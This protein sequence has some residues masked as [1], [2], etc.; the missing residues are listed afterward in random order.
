MISKNIAKQG[1]ATYNPTYV[2]M[3]Y[4]LPSTQAYLTKSWLKQVGLDMVE[5]VK[6]MMISGKNFRTR[7]SG[8]YDTS[9]L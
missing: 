1:Y 8:E 3:A 9:T 6:R 5:M 7:P 2:S 4:H